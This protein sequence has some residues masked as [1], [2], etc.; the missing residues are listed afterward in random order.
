[1][2]ASDTPARAAP[3]ETRNETMG[4]AL[5]L[6]T[7][8]VAPASPM[9]ISGV[10][11]MG[12][13]ATTH[14]TILPA[15]PFAALVGQETLQ[16]ALLLAAI[17]PG[18]GGVLISG[19]RGTAKSTSARALA[20]LLGERT[21]VNLPLGASEAQLIGSIDIERV[22]QDGRVGFSPGLLAKAHGGVLYVDEV[23]LLSD[24]LVDPLLD[25][26]AS[27]VNVVER[28]GISHQHA[29]RFVLIGTMNPEEGELRPQ[30]SDRFG[31][32]VV[33]RNCADPIERQRI[34]R[35]R[36]AFDADPVAF[37]AQ[38]ADAQRELALRVDAARVRLASLTFNDRLHDHVSRLCI[39]ADVDGLRADLV[40]LRAARALAALEGASAIEPMHADRVAELVLTHRRNAGDP[41]T[42][43]SPQG[44]KGS[45]TIPPK[46]DRT[47]RTAAPSTEHEE[48][49]NES[50]T[51]KGTG[52]GNGE[53]TGNGNGNGSG[54]R[55]GK[56]RPEADSDGTD[57][58]D[59]GYL[60]PEPA[61]PVTNKVL[62]PFFAKKV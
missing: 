42:D 38:H 17:D 27:G 54:D 39:A 61:A 60:A 23:N 21:F 8:A 46:Q 53:R 59:W 15:F 13:T 49:R 55:N 31:L 3:V 18:I 22:L 9:S 37:C 26:S 51:S 16:C 44:A 10:D 24:A 14:A 29:A 36:L 28:E 34:V 45:G 41:A 6:S 20:D 33:L 52:A 2:S 35:T 5:L 11:A 25:V 1:M 4:E 40:M 30:L 50:V 62:R 47:D 7:A 19:P 57:E 12:A 32:A 43:A 58:P 56:A 48:Q